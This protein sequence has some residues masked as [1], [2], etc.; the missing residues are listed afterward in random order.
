MDK[1]LEYLVWALSIIDDYYKR[2]GEIGFA[3]AIVWK[4][5]KAHCRAEQK[6]VETPSGEVETPSVNNE[7]S[8]D[9]C[10]YGI[11]YLTV[12]KKIKANESMCVAGNVAEWKLC[13]AEDKKQCECP[14]SFAQQLQ[15]VIYDLA[16]VDSVIEE[17]GVTS[18]SKSHEMVSRSVRR[19]TALKE[20]TL[21]A[22]Q[23]ESEISVFVNRLEHYSDCDNDELLS[24]II[25]DMEQLIKH[26]EAA[27]ETMRQPSVS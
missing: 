21:S 9:N 15:N 5:A 17:H 12:S 14:A 24:D 1:T 2:T 3:E 19:L 22:Q 18:N 13:K 23:L 11:C 20:K 16:Y 27:D 25:K 8:C 4:A 10:E 26:E 7:Y 6:G